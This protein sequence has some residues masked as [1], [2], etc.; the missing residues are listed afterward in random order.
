MK[1]VFGLFFAFVLTANISVADELKVAVVDIS[2]IE[3]NAL[4]TKDL[5]KKAQAKEKEISKQL[6]T[7]RSKLEKDLKDLESKK[8]VLSREAMEKQATKLQQDYMQ[9]QID[10]KVYA[11][12]FEMVRM[13]SMGEI[14]QYAQQAVNKVADGKYDVVLPTASLMYYNTKKFDDITSDVIDKLNGISKTINFDKLFKEA[15][16]QAD[17]MAKEQLGK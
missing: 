10:E 1:K 11:Q 15:K 16:N 6:E 4:I 8:A 13:S 5:M 17:K 3:Q 12:A 2:R 9:A 7:K 14:Q